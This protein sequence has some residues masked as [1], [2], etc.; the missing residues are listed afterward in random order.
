MYNM[1]CCALTNSMRIHNHGKQNLKNTSI[2]KRQNLIA[3]RQC[4]EKL[5]VRLKREMALAFQASP[6]EIAAMIHFLYI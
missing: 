1:Y 3:E 2:F 4:F 5:H 6:A